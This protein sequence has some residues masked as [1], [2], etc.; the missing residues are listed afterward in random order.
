[1]LFGHL[2]F[3]NVFAVVT[4]LIDVGLGLALTRWRVEF[5]RATAQ[6]QRRFGPLG[7]R[8]AA[9]ADPRWALAVGVGFIAFGVLSI[10]LGLLLKLEH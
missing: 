3:D 8:S 5:T 10:C 1:M 4:G 9:H 7:R 6:V 2:A